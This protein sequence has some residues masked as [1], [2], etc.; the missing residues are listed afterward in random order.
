MAR[1]RTPKFQDPAQIRPCGGSCGRPT[2]PSAY[3]V[4]DWPGTVSRQ[5][6]THC[7]PCK[8]ERDGT[9]QQDYRSLVTEEQTARNMD[10]LNGWLNRKAQLAGRARRQQMVRL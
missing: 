2:R 4:A 7:A 10:A 8:N 9:R 6:A 1:N 3:R 5:D